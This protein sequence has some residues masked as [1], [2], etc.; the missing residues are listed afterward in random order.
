VSEELSLFTS[1][2]SVINVNGEMVLARGLI[3]MVPI[4]AARRPD[5]TRTNSE[6]TKQRTTIAKATE[7]PVITLTGM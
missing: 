5:L 2:A 1:P 7:I 6:T 3:S 4:F